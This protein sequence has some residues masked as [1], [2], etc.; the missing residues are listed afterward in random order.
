MENDMNHKIAMFTV[1]LVW[2]SSG[3]AGPST[4]ATPI[5]P[6]GGAAAAV[7]SRGAVVDELA[8][9]KTHGRLITPPSFVEG[10]EWRTTSAEP[11][12]VCIRFFVTR[13]RFEEGAI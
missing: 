7:P 1:L 12:E 4:D 11:A 13:Q 2:S 3:C 10:E 6:G 9:M 5:D 8:S